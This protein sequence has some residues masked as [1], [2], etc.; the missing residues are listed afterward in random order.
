[1]QNYHDLSHEELMIPLVYWNGPPKH[2]IT[3]MYIQRSRRSGDII[4]TDSYH[5]EY[6]LWR[7]EMSCI[8]VCSSY[9]TVDKTLFLLNP[10]LCHK[11]DK[12][13]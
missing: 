13:T 4:V 12:T 8:I 3:A 2:R 9:L 7:P 6:I 1:M 5:G 11:Q 10:K